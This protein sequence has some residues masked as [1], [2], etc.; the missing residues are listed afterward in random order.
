MLLLRSVVRRILIGEVLL[1]LFSLCFGFDGAYAGEAKLGTRTF[2]FNDERVREITTE[3]WYPAADTAHEIAFAPRP[4]F[5]PIQIAREAAYCCESENGRPL[6][7]ISHGVFGNRFSQGWLARTLVTHGYIVASVTHPNT[8]A[9][10]ITPAGLYRLWD[11]A[12]D[13]SVAIDSLLRDPDW[14]KRI[15]QRRIAFVGHSFGGATGAIL[16]GGSHDAAALIRFCKT[17]AAAK[18][19]YCEPLAKLEPQSL[20]VRLS[21]NSY[22]DPR[23]RAF[24]IMASTPAQGFKLESL[25]SI[26]V[27]FVVDTAAQDEILD[28]GLNAHV[29]AREIPGASAV[30]RPV[31]HF[32]YV[33]EC[34]AGAVPPQAVTLCSD[35]AGVQRAA[36]HQA[37]GETVLQF[38]GKHL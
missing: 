17:P 18:D 4:F 19:T 38:L 35:P 14:T 7:V 11:R 26:R 25:R 28:N 15:D 8:T 3:I 31:G 9:D 12:G 2:S 20:D 32:A 22:Q 13:V 27:P 33:P 16:A 37:V 21:R 5:K 1:S 29:F 34:I 6:V 30:G 24:Y 10:D 23:I 36:V